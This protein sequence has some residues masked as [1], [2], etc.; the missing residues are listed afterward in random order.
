MPRTVAAST[1]EST[2]SSEFV[3]EVRQLLMKEVE[4]GQTPEALAKKLNLSVSTITLLAFP[5]KSSIT[6][7][8]TWIW[9][10]LNLS[11]DAAAKKILAKVLG[12][13]PDAEPAPAPAPKSAGR[14]AAAKKT[15]TK[16]PARR[17]AAS[18]PVTHADE[19]DD[20]EE[21]EEDDEEEET[22]E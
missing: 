1:D 18:V 15:A 14:P 20:E 12:P 5:G 8:A 17:G 4:S 9:A 2:V 3:D 10:Y 16:T 22:E 11:K 6:R 21:E 7:R 13:A 19:P